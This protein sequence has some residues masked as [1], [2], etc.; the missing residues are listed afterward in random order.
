MGPAHWILVDFVPKVIWPTL[1]GGSIYCFRSEIRDFLRRATKIGV[2][3]AEA[4][5]PE[6]QPQIAPP[7]TS[8]V[9]DV[10]GPP[11]DTPKLLLPTDDEVLIVVE[12]NVRDSVEQM[13][14]E[15]YNLEQAKELFI[16]EYAKLMLSSFYQ[17]V[18]H[19]IFGSQI[20]LMKFLIEQGPRTRFD[21]IFIFEEHAKKISESKGS[22]PPDFDKWIGYL[23]TSG[24]VSLSN[25]YYTI[26][27]LG[28]KFVVEF[29]Q[30][31]KI[32]EFNRPV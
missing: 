2:S 30:G 8:D 21:I 28:R 22:M 18:G 20:K 15:N 32:S 25:G 11:T 17:N 19:I 9:T 4:V 23:L 6:P 7:T 3:G 5:A 14:V 16:K 10:L 1:A 24:L 12:R 13:G 27:P 26:T 29:L 31:A